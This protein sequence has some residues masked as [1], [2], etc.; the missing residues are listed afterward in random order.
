MRHDGR[1]REARRTT[2]ALSFCSFLFLALAGLSARAEDVGDVS[3]DASA[4]Y[5]GSTTHGYAEIRVDLQNRSHDR[6]HTVTLVFPNTSIGSYGNSISR[7]TRTVTLPPESLQTVSLLQPP[8]PSQGDDSIRVEV[9]D[10]HTGQVHAPNA[11]SHCNDYS[12]EQQAATVFISRSLNDEAVEH[13]FN[14]NQGGFTPA[15]AVGAPDATSAGPQLTAWMPDS[16]QYG[17]TNWLELDYATPQTVN[18]ISIHETQSQKFPG[19]ITLI[20]TG[21]TNIAEIPMAAG[22]LT[23]G[24][25]G[26]VLECDFATTARPV[27]TIRLNFGKAP[28]YTI[29]IDAV[30]ISG[31]SGAQWA[32][33]ARASSDN[34]A[35][36][37]TYAPSSANPNSIVSMRSE[38]PVT[39]WSGNWLAYSPFDIMVLN[40]AD[41]SSMSPAVFNAIGNYLNAGGYVVLFGTADLPPAWHVWAQNSL[42]DGVDYRVGF[43]HCYIF[44]SGNPATLGRRTVQTLRAAVRESAA[45]W[46]ALPQD[47]NSAEGVLP[48]HG[49]LKVP[50]RGIVMVMLAFVVL[51]GPVNLIVLNRRKRRIWMLWTI[52][53]ISFATTLLVFMY[54]L[55]REGITPDTHIYGLTLLDQTSHHAATFGGE[56]F[57][58]PLTPGSGLH[59]EYETEATPL[60]RSGDYESSGTSREVDWTQSQHFGRGWVSAR[61][62]AYFQVRKSETSRER[63]EISSENG[64]LQIVNGLGAPIKSLWLADGNM[65]FYAVNNVAAGDKTALTAAKGLIN[66][67]QAGPDGLK[68]DLGFGVGS[69]DNLANTA[70][71]YLRPNTYIAVLDGNPFVENALNPGMAGN[72][73]HLKSLTVVYGILEAPNP[74]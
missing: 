70:Q 57:Y 42:E 72:G 31:P 16:R 32:S 34:S 69:A 20:G 56:S 28:P 11:N 58:C 50:V 29:A 54:S 74:K 1:C 5:T 22:T 53:A 3:A 49:N 17:N 9:D 7:I 68:R 13:L 19:T 62:P 23:S 60:V 46:P 24:G 41:I 44:N 51:I 18:K 38:S 48:V 33:D 67:G 65:N 10:G 66:P 45:Y 47:N 59:F 37:S 2:G 64:T 55:L 25:V 30:E 35:Q 71:T 8:L 52:P 36:A 14:A 40:A 15:T 26:W 39:E 27:K 43:G 6:S 4:I 73:K 63:I 21:G 12:R 61:V